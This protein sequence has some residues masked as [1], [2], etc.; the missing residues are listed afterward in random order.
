MILLATTG[1]GMVPM[2]AQLMAQAGFSADAITLYRFLVPFL[3]FL[4]WFRPLGLDPMESMRT[5]LIGAFGGIGMV[6]F[7]RALSGT[8]ATTVILLY[9]CYPFFSILL[10][11]LFFDQPMTRN[12]F[13][14]ALLILVAASLTFNPEV[15]S[16]SD[17]PLILASLLAPISFALM[18]QYLARPVKTMK[19]NQRMVISLSGTLLMAVPLTMFSGPLSLSPEYSIGYAWIITIGVVSAALPQYLFARGA[20]LAGA[21]STASLSS[22]E[23]VIAMLMAALIMGQQPDRMQTTAAMLIIIAQLIRQDFVSAAS[24]KPEE[25]RTT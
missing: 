19:T 22:L 5:L 15:M 11:A 12:S 10:G 13:S 9:Y 25:Q 16:A 1:F 18:I 14:S 20:P 6:L 21:S 4:P 3:L 2:L 17:L 23:V 24:S 7:M 8:S